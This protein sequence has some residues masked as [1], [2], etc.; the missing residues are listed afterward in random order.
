VIETR[1]ERTESMVW[2][3][4]ADRELSLAIYAF[5]SRHPDGA[6][7]FI[8]AMDASDSVFPIDTAGTRTDGP[9]PPGAYGWLLDLAREHGLM[10]PGDEEGG[11]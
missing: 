11:P 3:Y 2:I 1:I 4:G 5:G 9:G 8:N 10:F 6:I 7:A